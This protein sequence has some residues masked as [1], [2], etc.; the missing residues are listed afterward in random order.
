[1][2][3]HY[4]KKHCSGP[5]GS[6]VYTLKWTSLIKP[7]LILCAVDVSLL[8]GLRFCSLG[9]SVILKCISEL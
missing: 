5:A 6:W 7:D 2:A 4:Q 3:V 9:A 8:Q 1:M